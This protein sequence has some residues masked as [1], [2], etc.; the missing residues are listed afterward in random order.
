MR[1]EVIP[2][3]IVDNAWFIRDTVGKIKFPTST[4]KFLCDFYCK[5][6]N[7]VYE[8]KEVFYDG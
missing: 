6:L 3:N 7:T 4:N 5:A 1:F 2:S 8:E